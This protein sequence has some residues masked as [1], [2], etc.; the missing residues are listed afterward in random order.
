MAAPA[1]R[2]SSVAYNTGGNPTTT[3]TL[4]VG[5]EQGDFLI[6]AFNS[7]SSASTIVTPPPGWVAS[8]PHGIYG[9]GAYSV[10][11]KFAAP[12]EPN[13]AWTMSSQPVV[14][15]SIVAY[16][17][18]DANAPVDVLPPPVQSRPGVQT[19]TVAPSVVTLGVDRTIVALYVAKDTNSTIITDPPGTTRRAIQLGHIATGTPSVLAV[20]TVAAVAGATPTYTATYNVSSANGVGITLALKSGAPPEPEPTITHSWIGN[21]TDSSATVSVRMLNAST[22]DLVIDARTISGVPNVNGV[23]KLHVS[24]L[25]ADTPYPYTIQVDGVTL[26][27]GTLRTF[28][29]HG[30]LASYSIAFGSCQDTGSNPASFADIAAKQPRLMVHLGDKDYLDLSTADTQPVI[31]SYVGWL[32]QANINTILTNTPMVYTWDNHDWGGTDSDKDSLVGP[33]M[34][35]TYREFAPHWPLPSLN[36]SIYQSFVIGRVRY[37][38]L[39]TRSQRDPITDPDTGSKSMLGLEQKTWLKNELS[40]PEPVKVIGCGIMWRDT[41]GE[42]GDRWGSFSNEFA[43]INQYIADNQITGVYVISGDRHALAA[44]DGTNSGG[45]IPNAVAAPFYQVTTGASESW[46]HGYYRSEGYQSYYG[47]LDVVD[48]GDTITL[49]Y[50]GRDSADVIQVQMSTVYPV[51]TAPDTAATV[52]ITGDL[53]RPQPNG[54]PITGEVTLTPPDWQTAG[55]KTYVISPVT[56]EIVAGKFTLTVIVTQTL[57]WK[58]QVAPK[59]AS[60]RTFTLPLDTTM[61]TIDISELVQASP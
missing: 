39:D 11:T 40:Q 45:G 6:A 10:W 28:P 46:S 20:D 35:T 8:K 9:N 25:E 3:C 4:P 55:T 26:R 19:T 32:S 12:G 48:A 16:S 54:E 52:T 53:N 24:D 58:L 43:E 47:L 7:S 15:V 31:D 27:S 18:V 29:K 61:T 60:P 22:V 34:R 56:A 44:D 42:A 36:Q 50:T 51:D 59:A 57:T 37:I 21:V 49:N 30:S 1:Y 17:G 14:A 2:A 5:W 41:G 13:P 38:I 23:V 33:A